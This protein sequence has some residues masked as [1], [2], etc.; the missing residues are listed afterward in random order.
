LL[1]HPVDGDGNGDALPAASCTA[2]NQAAAKQLLNLLA[3]SAH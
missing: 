1:E 2:E 3:N